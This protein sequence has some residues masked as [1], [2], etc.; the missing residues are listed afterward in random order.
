MHRLTTLIAALV[1]TL[2][3]VLSAPVRAQDQQTPDYD[4]WNKAAD[5]AEQ[6]VESGQANGERLQAIRDEVVKWRDRFKAA[7]GTNAPRI[8]TIKD[9]IAA[10][11]PAPAEGQSESDDIA[12]RRKELN[13]QLSQLQA[14]GLQAV[15]AFGRADGIVQQIDQT[16]RQRQTNALIRQTPLPVNPANWTPALTEAGAVGGRVYAEVK[17]SWSDFGSGPDLTP[18]LLTT[19]GFLAAALLLLSRGRQWVDSLPGRLSARA[20][21]RSRAALVF[22]VSLGQI[23]IPLI[24]IVLGVAALLATDLFGDWGEPILKSIP[25]A[26]LAFFGG[27]W[28]VRRVFPEPGT[29]LDMPL[30]IDDDHRRQAA[31][32]AT[33]LAMAVA[34]H[35]IARS[36]LPLSGFNAQSDAASVPQRLDEASAGVW[37]FLIILLGA[38]FLFQ[39]CNILRKLRPSDAVAAPDYR[40]RVVAFLGAMARIVALLAP[41][42]AAAGYVTGANAVLWSTIMTLALVG[43]LIVLQDFTADLY[44]MAKGGD[45]SARDALMPVLISFALVVLSLPLFSLVWGARPS[46]LAEA[47]S[48]LQQGFNL[49]GVRLSPMGLLTFVIVFAVGYFLTNFVQGAMRS[50]ILPKTKL[51]VGGQS[52]V[53]SMIGYVGVALAAVFAITSAGIDLTSLAF[54]AGALSVGIGFGMQQV[55]SNFVSGIILL[56]ERPIAVGDWIEVGGQQGIVKKMAVRATQIQTFDRTQIIV[57]NSNLITQPVT[58]W[59]RTSLQGRI[60]VPIT[61]GVTS[62]SQQVT[63]LLTEI[64]ED[65]PTVLINPA[66]VVLLRSITASGL[67]FELRAVISDINGGVGVVSQINH[68]I[69][70]RFAQANIALPGSARASQDVYLHKAEDAPEIA[71]VPAGSDADSA[72]LADRDLPTNTGAEYSPSG[73]QDDDRGDRK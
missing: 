33:M 16:I 32:R 24:G 50:S 8:A 40:V 38:F 66:P 55:V 35:Q 13:D 11:G 70:S 58:N 62:D 27:F 49:G 5:Q 36:V 45:R 26:G 18:R 7:E 22:A 14:P 3:L 73:A 51:D 39:L 4:A 72:A 56:V 54:V 52:A 47:W 43:L 23:A 60:I 34:I 2:S 1:V 6:I 41:I 44:A 28:L 29:V 12:A 37:H 17:S 25:A 71:P 20:S 15:E 65:Q 53:A 59:T 68:Q 63:Q 48:R 21:E 69:L 30:P 19:L 9:Q 31:F 10:L 42:A 64:A 67:N 61:V 46:D 57:P